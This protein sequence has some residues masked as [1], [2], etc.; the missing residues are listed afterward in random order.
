MSSHVG[1][2]SQ[3]HCELEH[4][5][6]GQNSEESTRMRE[7]EHWAADSGDRLCRRYQSMNTNN[8]FF[9]ILFFVVVDHIGH[10]LWREGS[11]SFWPNIWALLRMRTEF[12]PQKKK[13]RF[14]S[15]SS[16]IQTVFSRS[17]KRRGLTD[18][19]NIAHVFY[20]DVFAYKC[21]LSFLCI[22]IFPQVTLY[23]TH[24]S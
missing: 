7:Q 14:V 24:F 5:H 23:E 16:Q 12:S 4:S 15:P 18:T 17:N 20:K 8:F 2:F 1:D 10:G 22:V 3:E 11:R 19:I 6:T 13:K 9:W 21:L